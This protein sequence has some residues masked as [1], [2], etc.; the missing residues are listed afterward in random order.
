MEP[1]TTFAR[2]N[3]TLED[4]LHDLRRLRAQKILKSAQE[5]AFRNGTSNMTLDETNAEIAATRA[6]KN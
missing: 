2:N 1:K 5:A 3:S 4:T 6:G